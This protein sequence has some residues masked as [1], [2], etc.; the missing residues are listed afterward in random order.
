MSWK[1][2]HPTWPSCSFKDYWFRELYLGLKVAA[3]F[4]RDESFTKTI[5]GQ[6]RCIT[7]EYN[8]QGT[9]L[10]WNVS[11]INVFIPAWMV[12]PIYRQSS[13]TCYCNHADSERETAS[14]RHSPDGKTGC[15]RRP[16]H[17][18][19]RLRHPPVLDS[20]DA[21]I[22]LPDRQINSSNTHN[23]ADTYQR[24]RPTTGTPSVEI[25]AHPYLPLSLDCNIQ[26]R[27]HPRAFDMH[28]STLLLGDCY[29]RAAAT[30]VTS[31][32][33]SCFLQQTCRPIFSA[34]T[35]G[36]GSTTNHPSVARR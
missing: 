10:A 34:S 13:G 11:Y 20:H 1:L 9:N 14:P 2:G 25:T 4:D 16:F 36:L 28:T 26:C 21:Q 27:P 6:I 18:L 29:V 15:A 12:P 33:D 17:N 8:S 31:W 19:R 30:S 3:S 22:H 5:D 32:S 7:P 35:C 23:Q 24:G